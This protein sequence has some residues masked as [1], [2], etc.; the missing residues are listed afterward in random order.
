LRTHLPETLLAANG[1]RSADR[2][3]ARVLWTHRRLIVL[4]ILVIM[5][6]TV[7]T[8]TSMY[9]T[10][11]AITT[12]KLRAYVAMAGTIVLGVAT[13]LFSFLG[14]CASDRWGRKPIM[15]WPRVAAVVLTVPAFLWLIS[16]PSLLH[17]AAVVTLLAAVTASSGTAVLTSIPEQFPNYIRATGVSLVY[18][19]GVSIFGSTT[20]PLVTWLIHRT[21]SAIVP[22]WY[23][24]AINSLSAV[25]VLLLVES[26]H[27]PV[28]PAAPKAGADGT[29]PLAVAPDPTEP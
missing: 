7:T 18:A 2:V 19:L 20:Q 23:V 26:R 9:M 6:T 11:Y 17:L 13:A 12:L 29:L 8:Y 15:L 24:V 21:G 25:A 28:S 14:G 5:S 27:V 1:K 22:A 4:G 3:S 16:S 10:S